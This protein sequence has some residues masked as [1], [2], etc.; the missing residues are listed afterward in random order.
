MFENSVEKNTAVV[1]LN[2]Q[3]EFNT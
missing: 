2:N 3:I 1:F